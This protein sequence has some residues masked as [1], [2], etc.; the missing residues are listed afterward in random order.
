MKPLIY[1]ICKK[2]W[3]VHVHYLNQ[4]TLHIVPFGSPGMNENNQCYFTWNK[5]SHPVSLPVDQ[6][7]PI[8]TGKL[9]FLPT[10]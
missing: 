5:S 4:I 10:I 7:M 8:D 3:L 6:L 2:C 9:E 1:I